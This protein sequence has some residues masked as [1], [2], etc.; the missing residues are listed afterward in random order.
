VLIIAVILLVWDGC[1]KKAQL[2]AFKKE[3]SKL[4]SSEQ[5]FKE[6]INEQGYK[7]AEQD[8]LILSQKDAIN[9]N[10]L[11][12]KDLK[13]VSSQVR[14]KTETRV[15]SIFVPFVKTDTIKINSENF[16][17]QR[18]S[19]TNQ[20]YSFDGVTKID[21]ILLDSVSFNGGL[22]VTIGYKKEGFFKKAKPIVAVDY[23]N[24]YINTTSLQNIVIKEDKKWYQ[25]NGTWFG[26]G[27][28]IGVIGTF[29]IK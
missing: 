7:I 25:K 27:I 6:T 20:H 18:F 2:S 15:D 13:K 22:D 17:P 3:M 14:I 10:L 21:G 26:I 23:D 19:L 4:T 28:G 5:V 29:L 1:S 16:V 24:P 11:V 12:I 8:Q 9:N